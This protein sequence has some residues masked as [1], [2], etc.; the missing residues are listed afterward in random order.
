MDRQKLR[1]ILHSLPVKQ[2]LAFAEAVGTSVAY[3][4]QLAGNH[5]T[6]S[7]HLCITLERVA[8]EFDFDL[9]R[10]DL[11]DDARAIWGKKQ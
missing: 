6:P 2:R 4:Y 10:W 3:L 11:R 7:P 1:K 5:S 8:C 9:T